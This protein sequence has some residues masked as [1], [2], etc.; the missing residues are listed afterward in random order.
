VD[1]GWD[2]GV[3]PASNQSRAISDERRVRE[4]NLPPPL[5]ILRSQFLH[6]YPLILTVQRMIK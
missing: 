1:N 6:P 3:F 4:I 5:T 2:E